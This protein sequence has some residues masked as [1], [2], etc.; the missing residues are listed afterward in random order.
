MRDMPAPAAAAVGVS[1][2]PPPAVASIGAD[3]ILCVV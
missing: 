3:S 1:G 2:N